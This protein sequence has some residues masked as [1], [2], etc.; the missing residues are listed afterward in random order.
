[1]N[2][3]K[4]DDGRWLLETGRYVLPIT[5]DDVTSLAELT[6]F[7]LKFEGFGFD[8]FGGLYAYVS[9]GRTIHIAFS[10]EVEEVVKYLHENT[11]AIDG[12]A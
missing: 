2:L 7:R 6:A 9:G 4:M 5:D 11:R 10:D 8:Y 12:E 1:M 3:T